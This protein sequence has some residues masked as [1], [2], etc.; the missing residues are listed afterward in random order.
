M[1][2]QNEE[3]LNKDELERTSI[4]DSSYPVSREAMDAA[5]SG[6]ESSRIVCNINHGSIVYISGNKHPTI[7]LNS[8]PSQ[9]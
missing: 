8:P 6:G 4:E 5:P 2:P 3:S 7:N 9:E 1:T